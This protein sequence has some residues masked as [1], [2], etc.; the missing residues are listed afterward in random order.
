MI[1]EQILLDI[2]LSDLSKS[3]IEEEYVNYF[4]EKPGK[5]HYK[6]LAYFSLSYNDCTIIDIGSYKGCSALALSYNKNNKVVSFDIVDG[7]KRLYYNYPDNIQFIVDSVLEEKYKSLILNSP[8]I[9]LDTYHD[10]PFENVFYQ[11][12]KNIKYNGLLLLDDIKLNEPMVS[13]WNNIE[14]EK[15]DIS[16]YGH[17]S[18]TGIVIFNNK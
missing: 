11:Y 14:L 15:H 12:L 3:I 5:E 7:L 6:L 13:F 9:M 4:L 17:H 16:Q 18:G 10:G 2:D 1:K 8:F